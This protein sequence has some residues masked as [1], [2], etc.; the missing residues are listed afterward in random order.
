[1]EEKKDEDGEKSSDKRPTAPPMR[2]WLSLDP[3]GETQLFCFFSRG[4]ILIPIGFLRLAKGRKTALLLPLFDDDKR[5][6]YLFL[7][8]RVE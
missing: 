5:F 1:L 6:L 8:K 3:D 7:I 2:K 4:R